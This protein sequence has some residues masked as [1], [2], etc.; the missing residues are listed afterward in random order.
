MIRRALHGLATQDDLQQR[1]AIFH[2]QCP[3]GYEV[4]SFIVDRGSCA[5]MASKAML[6]NLKLAVI[7]HPKPY[8]I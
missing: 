2:T 3:M 4:C 6:K 5:N 8:T 1:E 7:T